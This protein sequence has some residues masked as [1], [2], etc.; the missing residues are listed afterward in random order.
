MTNSPIGYDD[1]DAT[2]MVDAM[3]KRRWRCASFAFASGHHRQRTDGAGCL[4]G[5]LPVATESS[6]TPW[7]R[8]QSTGHHRTS[9]IHM[10]TGA[11]RK[12]AEV[13]SGCTEVSMKHSR[14]ARSRPIVFVTVAG[15]SDVVVAKMDSNENDEDHAQVRSQHVAACTTVIVPLNPTTARSACRFLPS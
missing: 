1:A 9:C 7:H 15:L 12:A 14:K 11:S 10:R 3:N 2:Y 6:S 13:R 5:T 8:N 4:F